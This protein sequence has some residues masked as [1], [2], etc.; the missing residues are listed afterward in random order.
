VNL[1]L[2]L[3]LYMLLQILLLQKLH[4]L[5]LHLPTQIYLLVQKLLLDFL[6]VDLLVGYFLFLQLERYENYLL[7]Q[8]LLEIQQN[9]L[10]Y[11]HHLLM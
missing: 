8:N 2:L 5:H 4:R 1:F 3:L 6:V 10:N 9:I 7:H 11:F